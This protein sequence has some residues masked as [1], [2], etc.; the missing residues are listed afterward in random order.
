VL[1]DVRLDPALH[2]PYEVDVSD[3]TGARTYFLER[4]PHVLASLDRA[5]LGVLEGAG[6][7][8]VDWYDG[9]H[10]LRAMDEACR[11]RVPVF[12]NFEFGHQQSDLLQR[13]ADRAT[14]CQAVA[15]AAQRGGDAN[16]VADALLAAGV[17]LVLVT[18]AGEGCLVA[19]ADQR[20]R[21]QAIPVEA[22]DGCGAGAP[23]SAGFMNCWLR[24]EDLGSAARFA[25]AAASLKCTVVGMHV[26][27]RPEVRALADQLVVQ[28]VV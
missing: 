28:S 16:N 27:P 12:L 7:L 25:S 3:R 20:L 2:T 14:I 19:T 18:L 11:L 15:D 10:I 9:D 17:E 6:M 4:H 23:F 24:G 8:C 5:D 21:L 22:V 26:R 13:Y 1:G